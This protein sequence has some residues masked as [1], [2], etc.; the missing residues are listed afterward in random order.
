[1]ATVRTLA[2]IAFRPEA[3][4]VHAQTFEFPINVLEIQF[5]FGNAKT[6]G[7]YQKQIF[8]TNLHLL[9]AVHGISKMKLSFQS[10][11]WEFR[12]FRH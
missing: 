11:D 8:T 7:L 2:C 12:T 10:I 4:H 1:M 5:H 9:N 6:F 3:L